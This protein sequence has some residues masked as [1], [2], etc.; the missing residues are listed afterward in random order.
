MT[1]TAWQECAV[2][3]FWLS[4]PEVALLGAVF[5]ASYG[6][7]VLKMA[8]ERG[9]DTLLL[10]G[11]TMTAA[12]ITALI[13]SWVTEG[14]PVLKAVESCYTV[15][16]DTLLCSI[17]G[18]KGAS[19][20]LFIGYTVAL[21]LLINVIAFNIYG[22]LLRRYS[23]TFV[24]FVGF[25]TPLFAA[26]FGWLFLGETIGWPFIA[27]MGIIFVGLYLFYQDEF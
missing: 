17:F 25:I 6:W 14:R 4:L 1:D 26:L 21:I 11:Y 22:Y 15:N 13:S 24:S 3:D 9:Y 12:G 16:H 7:I 8:Q 23:I 5:S 19:L 2:S 10:N 27:S 18:P 20:L